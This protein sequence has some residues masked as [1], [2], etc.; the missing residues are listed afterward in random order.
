MQ[1]TKQGESGRVI[2]NQ[3][4]HR[5]APSW[6]SSDVTAAPA[7]VDAAATA[8]AAAAGIRTSS[9]SNAGTQSRAVRAATALTRLQVREHR[10]RGHAPCARGGLGCS[11][12]TLFC[13]RCTQQLCATISVCQLPTLKLH[14]TLAKRLQTTTLCAA[15][16][17]GHLG[18]GIVSSV[19]VLWVWVARTIDPL[20]PFNM[21]CFTERQRS[22]STAQRC[23]HATAQH[24]TA[25]HGLQP[26]DDGTGQRLSGAA[27]RGCG[28]QQHIAA[29]QEASGGAHG[30]SAAA[31]G[32]SVIA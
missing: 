1:T 3:Q 7:A 13:N 10:Y 15:G 25:R 17:S 26:R 8:A 9:S 21:Q 32:G 12:Q 11:Q 2:Q 20:P 31:R 18:L 6:S 27:A 16:A 19:Y 23:W 14:V 30:A 24:S 4:P 5:A 29:Q 22:A 28:K